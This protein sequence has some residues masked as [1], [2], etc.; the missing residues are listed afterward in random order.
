MI[1]LGIDTA[2]TPLSVAIVKD[3]AILAEVNSSMA[4]NHS[5]RAMPVIEELFETV[6]LKPNDIDA[7]AVSEGPGSYTGVRIGVTIA[8]TLAW[9][10]K[11]P[12]VGV[13]SLKTLAANAVFFNGLICPLVD[14]RRNNVYAGVY[15]FIDGELIAI[16][17]DQHL[18]IED[19]L[20]SLKGQK[21]SVL[22]VGKDVGMFEEQI[23]DIM[24][25]NAVIAP[26]PMQ[27]PRASSLI[28]MAQ[29]SGHEENTH[30]FTP[31]Y[32]RIAEAEANWL[33]QQ[34]KEKGSD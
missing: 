25:E 29:Q 7:I 18:G 4:V 17:E 1:W 13:S 11:K 6:Q 24:K 20:D 32:R 19:L 8:K 9:T 5:L 30:A 10:L 27:L 12:L 16:H 33:L 28:F 31:E 21:R 3:G 2:N 23:M 22:F 14:A 26:F 15:E 34:R